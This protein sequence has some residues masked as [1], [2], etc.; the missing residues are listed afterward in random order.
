MEARHPTF[1]GSRRGS[2]M[3]MQMQEVFSI[4]NKH[5]KNHNHK[6]LKRGGNL[7]LCYRWNGALNINMLQSQK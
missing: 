4:E 5:K 6:E 3:L 1:K 7:C 2:S